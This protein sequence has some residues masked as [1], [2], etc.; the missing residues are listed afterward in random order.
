METATWSTGD[1]WSDRIKRNATMNEAE[2]RGSIEGISAVK[3]T[4]VEKRRLLN[5]KGLRRLI[6]LA[7]TGRGKCKWARRLLAGR[8][9][10]A[11]ILA[12]IGDSLLML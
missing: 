12:A 11:S 3:A 5:G 4:K 8:P 1:V 7:V 2:R 6:V 9:R 10:L